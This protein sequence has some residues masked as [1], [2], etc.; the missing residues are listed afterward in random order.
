MPSINQYDSKRAVYVTPY[1]GA[2]IL[3]GFKTNCKATTSTACGHTDVDFAAIPAGLV[4]GANAPKPGRAS[5]KD[6]AEHES[7]FYDPSV[8]AALIAD[9]WSLSRGFS[10]RPTITELSVT[11]SVSTNSDGTTTGPIKYAWNMPIT[12]YNAIEAELTA[13][14]IDLPAAG[15]RD[16]VFG[17][18][19]PNVPRAEKEV[20]GRKYSTFVAPAKLDSLPAGW[21]PAGGSRVYNA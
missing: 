20:A 5:K 17:A 18:S 10:R 8:R 4:F 2:T 13:L 12:K 16:L 19:A 3:Y 14:G 11:V 21:S 15:D 9:G 1:T 6:T 7:S